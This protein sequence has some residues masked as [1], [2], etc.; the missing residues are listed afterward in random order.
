MERCLVAVEGS[1]PHHGLALSDTPSTNPPVTA[2]L[3]DTHFIISCRD[4]LAK[5]W[6]L[7]HGSSLTATHCSILPATLQDELTSICIP[8]GAGPGQV[9]STI[10]MVSCCLHKGC[11]RFNMCV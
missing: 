3:N 8:S 9:A 6:Q 4:R 10:S 2:E 5:A 11:C 7:M 1:N